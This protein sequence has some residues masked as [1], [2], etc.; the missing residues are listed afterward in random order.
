MALTGNHHSRMTSLAFQ[1]WEIKQFLH[2]IVRGEK[3]QS[4]HAAKQG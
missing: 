1:K 2:R 3:V 4:D